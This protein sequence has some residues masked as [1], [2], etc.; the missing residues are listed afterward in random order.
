MASKSFATCL[1]RVQVKAELIVT[2]ACFAGLISWVV[3]QCGR[4]I[5]TVSIELFVA[6]RKRG[7]GIFD[8]HGHNGGEEEELH[9]IVDIRV[10]KDEKETRARY[11][12]RS[13]QK[14]IYPKQATRSA[15]AGKVG[16]DTVGTLSQ[17]TVQL[18]GDSNTARNMELIVAY[19][20]FVLQGSKARRKNESEHKT[21]AFS[22]WC[23]HRRISPK[24]QWI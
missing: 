8:Q 3:N 17:R 14:R 16:R 11:K 18:S 19:L 13:S 20:F 5:E 6:R 7:R 22:R 24:N 23:W 9:H 21:N 1:G 10:N 4:K 2:V 12:S 15:A